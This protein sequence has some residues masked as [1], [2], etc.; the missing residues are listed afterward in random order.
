MTGYAPI[1]GCDQ[2]DLSI[3]CLAT[4]LLPVKAREQFL[5]HF[6]SALR[7]S[8]LEQ[9][10]VSEKDVAWTVVD[11]DGEEVSSDIIIPFTSNSH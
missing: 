10:D 5:Q 11:S 8:S 3:T 9:T 6:K 1:L 7:F 4:I 2:L